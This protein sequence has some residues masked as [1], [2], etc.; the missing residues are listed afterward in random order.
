MKHQTRSNSKQN[1]K[2]SIYGKYN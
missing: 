1:N 2:H